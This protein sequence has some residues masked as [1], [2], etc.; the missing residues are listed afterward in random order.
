MKIFLLSL[1]TA[2][3]LRNDLALANPGGSAQIVDGRLKVQLSIN[4]GLS[5]GSYQLRSIL[6]QSGF[7]N[8]DGFVKTAKALAPLEIYNYLYDDGRYVFTIFLPVDD[9]GLFVSYDEKGFVSFTGVA[10]QRLFDVIKLIVPR[11][12]LTNLEQYKWTDSSYCDKTTSGAVEYRCW[13]D[14]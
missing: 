1:M 14:M 8:D 5:Q 2:V 6:I 3:F 9:K 10:A 7:Q 13:I 11:D 4:S 12:G